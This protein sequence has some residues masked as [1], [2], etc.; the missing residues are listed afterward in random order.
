MNKTAQIESFGTIGDRQIDLI[1]LR[2]EKGT[3]F[4]CLTYG[5]I[6]H[7][8]VIKDKNDQHLDVVVSPKGLHG[9][10]EQY[11]GKPYYFGTCIG[12]YA[13][14]ISNG[15]FKLR[16]DSYHLPEQNGVHLHGGNKGLWNKI[17]TVECIDEGNEPSVTLRCF[18][19]HLEQGYPG[20]LEVK[21]TYTLKGNNELHLL[22]EATTD[23]DTVL[24]LTNHTYF[25]VSGQSILSDQLQ[26]NALNVLEVD[27]KLLPTGAMVSV[28]DTALDFRRKCSIQKIDGIGGLD[29]TFI[30]DLSSSAPQISY[31]SLKSGIQLDI[32]T[33]QPSAVLFAPKSLDFMGSPKNGWMGGP[34]PA[35]CFETQNFPDAPNH[36]NFPSSVLNKGETYRSKTLY[37]FNNSV[38]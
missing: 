13:G 20:N 24:N 2:N 19:H 27:S 25:N 8:L 22:F 12:R 36:G 29:D 14:R 28:D 4:Q 6:W 5:A 17:W 18:S 16:G 26:I 33:D 15:C 32:T 38:I 37:T 23:K 7:S 30:F 3:T 10:L 21:V 9:Y 11:D 34:Y 1:S 31:T 35:I